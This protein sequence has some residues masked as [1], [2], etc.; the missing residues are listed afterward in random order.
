MPSF[1]FRF[2]HRWIPRRLGLSYSVGVDH[3]ILLSLKKGLSKIS[4][5]LFVSFSVSLFAA[6]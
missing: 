3:V 5:Y 4:F 6:L 2:S 1:Y